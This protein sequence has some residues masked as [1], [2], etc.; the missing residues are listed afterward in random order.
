MMIC[1]NL[2][3]K[4]IFLPLCVSLQLLKLCL[5]Q[6]EFDQE[7]VGVVFE[8]YTKF[9]DQQWDYEF[10]EIEAMLRLVS[11]KF[12][13]VSTYRMGTVAPGT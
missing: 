10:Q 6:I 3:C 4:F 12:S 9:H 2:L 7:Y 1:H 8:P 11:T 5:A 13:K